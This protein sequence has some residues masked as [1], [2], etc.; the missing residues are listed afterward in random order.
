MPVRRLRRAGARRPDAEAAESWLRPD[1]AGAGRPVDGSADGPG[2]LRGRLHRRRAARRLGALRRRD[3]GRQAGPRA[4]YPAVG[5]V[6]VRGRRG[7]AAGALESGDETTSRTA[8]SRRSASRS[9]ASSPARSWRRSTRTRTWHGRGSALPRS[10]SPGA[11]VTPP[12]RSRWTSSTWTCGRTC[13]RRSSGGGRDQAKG[14]LRVV[15][16]G[17]RDKLGAVLHE[18]VFAV[19]ALEAGGAREGPPAHGGVVPV[20]VGG[21]SRTTRTP[22][23]PPPYSRRPARRAFSGQRLRRVFTR[24]SHPRC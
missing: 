18:V 21:Q 19:G 3:P 23:R 8:T 13:R 17:V 4:G 6:A 2:P 15:P 10:G 11:R 12:G 7:A 16:Q 9:S 22:R 24:C 5:L 20:I 14:D 1:R